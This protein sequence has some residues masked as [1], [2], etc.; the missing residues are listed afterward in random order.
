MRPY[1]SCPTLSLWS[2]LLLSPSLS[3]NH[4]GL[5]AVTCTNEALSHLRSLHVLFHLPT[6]LFPKKIHVAY[7]QEPF[8]ALFKCQLICKASLTILFKIVTP[9]PNH[10]APIT[11]ASFPCFIACIYIWQTIYFHYLFT[12]EC[13]YYN[14]RDIFYCFVHSCSQCLEHT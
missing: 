5:L 10:S 1:T 8:R 9:S 11:L 6:M 4:T 13:K 12:L 2:Y 3:S 7:F 14:G